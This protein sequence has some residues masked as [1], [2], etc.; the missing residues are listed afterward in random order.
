[1]GLLN[2]QKTLEYL[3]DFLFLNHFNQFK[4][5]VGGRG[6]HRETS[7]PMFDVARRLLVDGRHLLTRLRLWAGDEACE[8]QGHG[9]HEDHYD[10]TS[11]N[12]LTCVLMTHLSLQERPWCDMHP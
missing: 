5:I 6:R 8:G 7:S 2:K 12:I 1:M 11:D 10:Q 4:M 3:G 9:D